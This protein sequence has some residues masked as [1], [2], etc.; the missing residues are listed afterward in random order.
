M[1]ATSPAGSSGSNL[2]AAVERVRIDE[3]GNV[4]IGISIPTHQVHVARS[5]NMNG[6]VYQNYTSWSGEA[7]TNAVPVCVAGEITNTGSESS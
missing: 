4:G 1:F 6:G 2:N 5:D 7:Q 3:N